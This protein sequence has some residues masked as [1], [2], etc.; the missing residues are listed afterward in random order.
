MM[1]QPTAP[2]GADSL[3]PPRWLQLLRGLW[4]LAALALM[5][6]FVAGIGLRYR[7]LSLVCAEP[8][9]TLALT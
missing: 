3:V 2:A 5:A 8:C 1:Q 6:L 9:V 7:E 4:L